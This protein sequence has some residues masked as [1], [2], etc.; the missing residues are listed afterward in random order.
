MMVKKC[1]YIKSG[2][3]VTILITFINMCA[4]IMRERLKYFE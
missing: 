1:S 2:C 3:K 4:I